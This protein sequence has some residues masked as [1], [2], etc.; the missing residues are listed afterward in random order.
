MI[1]E[2]LHNT[3]TTKTYHFGKDGVIEKLSM[4]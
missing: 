2:L 3:A 4:L 1:S